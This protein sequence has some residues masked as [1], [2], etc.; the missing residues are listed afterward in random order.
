MA[1]KKIGEKL[2]SVGTKLLPQTSRDFLKTKGVNTIADLEKYSKKE[3]QQLLGGSS[4][5]RKILK[6]L[7]ITGALGGAGTLG[8]KAGIPVGREMQKALDSQ[9][10]NKGGIVAPKMGGKP[11]HKAKK[12]SKSIAKKYFKGTF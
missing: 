3:L 12:N 11:S 6:T 1:L 5:G 4:V 7:G 8:F 2:I 9:K 10:M